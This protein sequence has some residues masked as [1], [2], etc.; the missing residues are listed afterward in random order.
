VRVEVIEDIDAFAAA[1]GELLARDEANHTVLL[2]ALQG[3]RQA[4]ARG[5]PLPDGWFSTVVIDGS[6]VVAAGRCWRRNWLMTT[7]P[8]EALRTLGHWAARRGD[9]SGI[10][11]PEDSVRAFEVGGGLAAR[12]H[13]ELPLMRLDGHPVQPHA[14]AGT[15]RT[16]SLDDL[17]LLLDWYEAFRVE[18]R[19]DQSAEQV[20]ADVERKARIGTQ[21]LWLDDADRP[22]GMIGGQTIAP[23]GARIGPVYTPPS[24]RGRGIGGAMVALLSQRLQQAGARCVFLFTDAANPTSNALYR[25]IGFSP[26]GRHLHRILVASG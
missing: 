8:T 10:V 25:R 1:A 23:T 4:R 17:E 21:Y 22:V 26:I 3:A 16:A 24:L 12:T 18:A 14:V 9:F 15:L 2:S 7:G 5:E 6:Q 11:G 13:V 19:I 20:A